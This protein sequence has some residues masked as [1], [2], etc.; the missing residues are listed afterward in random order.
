MIVV[1]SALLLFLV[2]YNSS[3]PNNK[4]ISS[5]DEWV[6]KCV[7]EFLDEVCANKS[8]SRGPA[9][10]NEILTNPDRLRELVKQCEMLYEIEVLKTP[11]ELVITPYAEFTEDGF[12]LM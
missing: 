5:R 9:A 7:Q 8:S 1:F 11:A 2:F 3:H 10:V 12:E 4:Q 6:D